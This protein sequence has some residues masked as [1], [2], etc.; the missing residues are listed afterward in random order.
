MMTE[1]HSLEH[2]ATQIL[3]NANC[4]WDGRSLAAPKNV[5]KV[6]AQIAFE[7]RLVACPFSGRSIRK[8]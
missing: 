6:L 4:R 5:E 2:Q 1:Q 7:R 8:H 3:K